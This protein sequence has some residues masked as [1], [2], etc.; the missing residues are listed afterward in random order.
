[1]MGMMGMNGTSP[2]MGAEPLTRLGTIHKYISIIST[3]LDL[4]SD[5]CIAW[6]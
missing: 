3:D 5:A 1:M 2:V 6:A 4:G